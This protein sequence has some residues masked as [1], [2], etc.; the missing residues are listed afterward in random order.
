M[1]KTDEVTIWKCDCTDFLRYTLSELKNENNQLK[2]Q[3]S[4][5]QSLKSKQQD[6]ARVFNIIYPPSYEY[7]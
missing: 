6:S 3:K 7:L 4:C 1:K 2:A 5:E